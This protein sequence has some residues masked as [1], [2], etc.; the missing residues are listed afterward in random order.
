MDSRPWSLTDLEN[1]CVLYGNIDGVIVGLGYY[2][3]LKSSY[4]VKIVMED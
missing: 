3:V 1:V 4:N 2:V